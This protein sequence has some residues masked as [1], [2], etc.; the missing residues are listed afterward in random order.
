MTYRSFAIDP[1]LTTT[2]WSVMEDGHVWVDAGLLK[3]QPRTGAVGVRIDSL[4][5]QLYR[6]LDDWKPVDVVIEVTSGHVNKGRHKGAGAG[7]GIYGMA[8]GELHRQC[9]WWASLHSHGQCYPQVHRIEENLWTA[10]RPKMESRNG[11]VS[12]V[13]LAR[14]LFGQYDPAQDPG[15]D[16]AD[17]LMLNCW[18][19]SQRKLQILEAL[20][21]RP[22]GQ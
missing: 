10:R 17:A 7:L 4:C 5:E 2:G 14:G 3:P 6:L 18:F 9:K 12:R 8:V 11:K 22:D 1:G 15:G 20:K 21:Y 16:L 19:Q 13:D